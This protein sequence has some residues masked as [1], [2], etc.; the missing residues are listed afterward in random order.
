[1]QG[2]ILLILPSPQ[3]FQ[4]RCTQRSRRARIF[5]K[6]RLCRFQ[7]STSAKQRIGGDTSPTNTLLDALHTQTMLANQNA[8]NVPEL[9]LADLGL[10]PLVDIEDLGRQ[11]YD[12]STDTAHTHWH[13]VVYGPSGPDPPPWRT[14][15]ATLR[16]PP[17]P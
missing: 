10:E 14:S 8:A 12:T 6:R 5:R 1:M 13:A 4:N 9:D 11:C 16:R 2:Q 17:P 15:Y 3:I 7:I